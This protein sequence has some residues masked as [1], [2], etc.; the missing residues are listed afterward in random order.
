MP[1]LTERERHIIDIM[2]QRIEHKFLREPMI[3]MNNA[4]GTNDEERYKKMI[5][6]LFLLDGEGDGFGDE[7]KISDWD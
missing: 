5:C 3:A 6:E 2:T 4:A 7:N 1:D